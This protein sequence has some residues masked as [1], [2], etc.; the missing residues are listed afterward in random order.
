ML[1]LLLSNCML[2]LATESFIFY[3]WEIVIT[4][5]VKIIIKNNFM[6]PSRTR[7]RLV[8]FKHMDLWYT[9]NLRFVQRCKCCVLLFFLLSAFQINLHTECCLSWL[10]IEFSTLK[11]FRGNFF[12][13]YRNYFFLS[14]NSAKFFDIKFFA[15]IFVTHNFFFDWMIDAEK[16]EIFFP[17]N[18]DQQK[19]VIFKDLNSCLVWYAKLFARI[20]GRN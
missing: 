5:I 4:I 16:C 19:C 18:W 1:A 12:K 8:T 13:F 9:R 14:K 10:M 15:V 6:T 11:R 7:H 20:M 3:V 2:A 17:N